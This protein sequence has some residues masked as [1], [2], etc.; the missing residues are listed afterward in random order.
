MLLSTIGV[1]R[2]P[3][4]FTRL[5][6][7]TK[8]TTVG[9]G[10]IM[11]AVALHFHAWGAS[12]RAAMILLLFALTTPVAA[13]VIA[14][15][16]YSVGIRLWSGTIADELRGRYDEVTHRLRSSESTEEPVEPPRRLE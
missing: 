8:A 16:A 12:L 10:A 9:I 15:A 5:Q 4:L 3:D 2:M 13:H 14:R 6:A 7:T 1:M 11:L